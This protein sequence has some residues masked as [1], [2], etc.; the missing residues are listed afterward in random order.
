ME[1]T[2]QRR[3]LF[4]VGFF[5]VLFLILVSPSIIPMLPI[6]PGQKEVIYS[7]PGESISLSNEEWF[8][9][10]F[11]IDDDHRD[12]GVGI[13]GVLFSH[14]KNEDNII[15]EFGHAHMS[16]YNFMALNDAD[17]IDSFESYG[18]GGGWGPIGTEYTSG[19]SSV[20]FVG[21]YVWAVRFIDLNNSSAV[22]QTDFEVCLQKI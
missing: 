9:R 17:K 18:S 3:V 1:G 21:V 16:F 19:Y 22:F 20:N 8:C 10:V 13:E 14:N 6:F 15:L 5:L 12:Y 7:S 2:T 4:L 11:V